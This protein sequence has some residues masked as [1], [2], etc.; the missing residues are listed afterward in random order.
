MKLFLNNHIVKRGETLEE[1]ASLY[2][3]DDIELLR[4]YH[5]QNVPK[6]GNHIGHTVF[7]GQEIF[8]PDREDIEEIVSRRKKHFEDKQHQIN[9]LILNSTLLP[10]F[11][12]IRQSYDVKIIDEYEDMSAN[13]TEYEVSI[14]YLGQDEQRYIFRLDRKSILV[15]G[16]IPD[17]KVY[18]LA[19]K[20]SAALF[21]LEFCISP[22]GKIV[23]IHHYRKMVNNWKT[24]K[25][26][27]LQKYEDQYS[28]RYIDIA[29]FT[30]ENKESLIRHLRR[31]LFLQFYF[32]PY[33]KKYQQG[34]SES[35]GY[36]INHE[37]EYKT[38]FE[39]NIEENIQITQS[40]EC[41]DARN[42]E[43]ILRYVEE[44]SEIHDDHELL[45]SKITGNFY[46][47]KE[48]K[49]IQ[50]ADIRIETYFYNVKEI[51]QVGIKSK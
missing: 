24:I 42:Q 27:L 17:L 41:V 31:D 26:K 3:I 18:Q 48:F 1:I 43:E 37:V 7:E 16:E 33:F 39:I 19:M 45:E 12:K 46:M 34:K 21:P 22:Q 6:N 20:C 40:S 44:T 51:T 35:I 50:N 2:K 30:I 47:D 36:F 25:H 4:F 13:E 38:Q 23:D 29:D 9:S 11:N 28:I 49:I 8:I 10:D 15:N 32:S 14:Q 5:H